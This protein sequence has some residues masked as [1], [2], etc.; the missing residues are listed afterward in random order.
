MGAAGKAQG[1]SLKS[2]LISFAV[3]IGVLSIIKL[4]TFNRSEAEILQSLKDLESRGASLDVEGCVDAV[5]DWRR[6]CEANKVMCNQSVAL[7]MAHCL[8][9][10]DRSDA[11][12]SL[13]RTGA[14]GQWVFDVCQE[15]G[16][17]CEVR[18]KC[19]CADAYRA[20]HSYCRTD[21]QSVQVQL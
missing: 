18:S 12:M 8:V 15:R 11:C 3:L 14:T 10:Q 4:I 1:P 20:L 9:P 2:V 21:Q 16:T 7:A 6:N 5:I 13:M 19:V 17:P